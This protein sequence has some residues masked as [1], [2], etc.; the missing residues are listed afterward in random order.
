MANNIVEQAIAGADL[1][2]LQY[3]PVYVDGADDE[4]VKLLTSKTGATG[5]GF[6]ANAPA[7]NEIAL[8]VVSGY[9]KAIAGATIEP[10]DMISVDGSTGK[11]ILAATTGTVILGQ[12]RPPLL[13]TTA[14]GRDAASGDLI[15]IWVYENKT[16]VI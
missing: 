13:G 12:Y 8:V 9:A 3:Y 4:R 15:R 14:T 5:M 1:S 11:V 7:D 16:N 6:L 2:A 10:Y